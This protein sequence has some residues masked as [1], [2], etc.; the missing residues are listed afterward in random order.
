[1][2]TGLSKTAISDG[3]GGSTLGQICMRLL[4]GGPLEFDKKSFLEV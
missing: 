1:M 3:K 2:Q 4:N